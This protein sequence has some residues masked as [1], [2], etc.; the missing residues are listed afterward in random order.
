MKR[1]VFIGT[2]TESILFGTGNVFVGKGKGIYIYQY[3]ESSPELKLCGVTQAG[4]N[5]SYLT[6]DSTHRFLYCVNELKEYEGVQSGAVSAFS[7]DAATGALHFLNRQ[8]TFG[9]DPCNLIV[10]R[11]GKNVL[12]A[13][14]A[15]GGVCVLPLHADGSLGAPTDVLQHTGSSRDP[16]RQSGPHAHG[17]TFDESGHYVFVPD[18][19][20][21]KLFIYFLDSEHGKLTPHDVPWLE[22]PAG[23]GPRQLVMHPTGRFA[24]LI[25]ELDSTVRAYQVE[26][27]PIGLKYLQTVSTLPQGYNGESE[28]GEL[29]ISP[30][31]RFL[32]ASN[33]GHDSIVTFSVDP[34]TGW[35]SA[36][37]FVSALGKTPRHFIVDPAGNSLLVVNQDSDNLVRYSL[38]PA[39]GL[40]TVVLQNLAVPSP[41]CVRVI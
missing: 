10:D 12:V 40:P 35:L 31:G 33:R 23:S 13:N 24:Y 11:A 1:L 37:G 19:G 39:S 20:A 28:C 38:D 41:V 7:I 9:T 16:L 30:G 6:F 18:L 34:V 5:P 15:S 22:I 8:P 25:D 17:I 21:D 2:Y 32:Y 4:P 26:R 29:Q 27:E 36:L 14:Y 3:E